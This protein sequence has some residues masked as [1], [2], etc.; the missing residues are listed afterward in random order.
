MPLP[1]VERSEQDVAQTVK[2]RVETLEDVRKCHHVAV[3]MTG[4]RVDITM[5]LSLDSNLRF[6]NVHKIVL[7]IDREVKRVI[8]NARVTVQTEP[9]GES[10]RNLV[11]AVI[12]IVQAA[13][14]SRGVEDIHIQ[15]VDGKLCVDLHLEVSA[16]AR[17][18]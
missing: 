9:V 15:K 3:R 17:A 6:E 2:K 4:K 10:R 1:L 8:P 11:A 5:R 12:E 7:N 13:P 16:S 14:G 18:L